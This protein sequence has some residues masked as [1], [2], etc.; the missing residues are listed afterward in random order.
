MPTFTAN[1]TK[2][3]LCANEACEQ[4]PWT[5]ACRQL[6]PLTPLCLLHDTCSAIVMMLPL[7]LPLPWSRQSKHHQL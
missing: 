2:C 3:G 7:P 5:S 6:V 4:N 1:R